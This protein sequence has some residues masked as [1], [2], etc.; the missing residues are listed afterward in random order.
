MIKITTS[1]KSSNPKY[2]YGPVPSRRLG[3][4]LGIDVVPFKTCTYNCI[5]CQLGHTTHLTNRRKNYVSEKALIAELK[6]V[7]KQKIKIDCI[8]FSGSGEPT[9]YKNLGRLIKKIK[10]F[11]DIPVAVITNS[12]LLS[13][14]AVQ[15][16]LMG[17]D[18]VLP[19]LTTTDERTF[20]KIHRPLAKIRAKKVIGG[21]INFRKKYPGKIYLELMLIKGFNDSPEEILKLKEAIA[22][23]KPD[24]VHLNTVVR[25]PSEDYAQPLKMQDL[26]QIK[27]MISGPSEVVA[28]FKKEINVAKIKDKR[29]LILRYLQ[30]RPGTRKDISKSLGVN[31]NELIKDLAQLWRAGKIRKKKYGGVVYY[32]RI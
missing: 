16:N 3:Y 2:I 17:A 14:P 32:E 25:P 24:K 8:T 11:T 23:I 22:R 4:S 7:L 30:R 5:Y 26:N 28:E 19:T 15:K 27:R 18:V 20:K 12:S 1:K 6:E 21:L 10:T 13:N 9:L 31:E 29:D